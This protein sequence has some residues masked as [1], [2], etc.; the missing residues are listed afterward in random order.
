MSLTFKTNQTSS[1]FSFLVGAMCTQLR[2]IFVKIWGQLPSEYTGYSIIWAKPGGVMC[3]HVCVCLSVCLEVGCLFLHWA[4][5][6]TDLSEPAEDQQRL[7]ARL[8]RLF[9]GKQV[10]SCRVW[11]WF[12]KISS[13]YIRLLW[14]VWHIIHF[15]CCLRDFTFA[16]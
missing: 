15:I 5:H 11:F 16:T 12:L 8:H 6:T 3:L 9:T 13:I 1:S 10:N 7:T 2:E 4:P 14:I